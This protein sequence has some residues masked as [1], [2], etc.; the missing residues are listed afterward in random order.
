MR[1]R[2]RARARDRKKDGERRRA[3]AH[4]H[5]HR[6]TH[7][8]KHRERERARHEVWR[9][10][11]VNTATMGEVAF[12]CSTAEY[13]NVVRVAQEGPLDGSITVCVV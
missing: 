11:G 5:T 12:I 10:V 1:A 6:H 4:T 2:K 7:K 3:H 8:K 13:V 9:L